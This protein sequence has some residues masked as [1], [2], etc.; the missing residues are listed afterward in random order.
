MPKMVDRI[1]KCCRQPFQARAA[2][3]KRGWGNYC[4]KSCK[5]N[6]QESVPRKPQ[7]PA[8]ANKSK[9]APPAWITGMFAG[10]SRMFDPH[11]PR[12]EEHEVG[13]FADAHLF[14]NEEHDC[15]KD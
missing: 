1:C 9:K 6:K 15:N 10:R 3:V 8:P 13:E 14:S 12:F 7:A 5:A 11:R 4:S 2:D